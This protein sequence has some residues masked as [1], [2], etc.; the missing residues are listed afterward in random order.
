MRLF[1]DAADKETAL[2]ELKERAQVLLPSAC[3]A[4]HGLVWG[5]GSP[6]ARIA[7]VGEAPGD[8]E[9]KLGR[10]FVDPA[11]I[12]R[13]LDESWYRRLG[14]FRRD[15]ALVADEVRKAA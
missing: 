7:I 2:S 14:E 4:G 11:G 13:Q 15:L 8:K 9:D 12:L 5:E 10:P 3:E 1:D 6:Y